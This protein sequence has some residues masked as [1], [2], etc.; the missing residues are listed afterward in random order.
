MELAEIQTLKRVKF[1][2]KVRRGLA[3]VRLLA[4]EAFDDDK[5]P[6]RTTHARWTRG[7]QAE[8]VAAMEWIK[9]NERGVA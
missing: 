5:P 3:L 1:T 9:Q 8:F 6:A 7:Q 2:D 4:V